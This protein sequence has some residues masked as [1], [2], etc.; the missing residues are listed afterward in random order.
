ML[1]LGL[2]PALSLAQACHPLNSQIRDVHVCYQAKNQSL[3]IRINASNWQLPLD[4]YS[5]SPMQI[6]P[7]WPNSEGF[8]LSYVD[9]AGFSA[10]GSVKVLWWRSGVLTPI[11]GDKLF[12]NLLYAF[13]IDGKVY[14]VLMQHYTEDFYYAS[15]IIEIGQDG[16]SETSDKLP[17]SKV[18]ADYKKKLNQSSDGYAKS[19][20]FAFIASAYIRMNDD[21][22]AQKYIALSKSEHAGVVPFLNSLPAISKLSQKPLQSGRWCNAIPSTHS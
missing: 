8:V 17:W 19:T 1:L 21:E 3:A 14:L 13:S 5:A 10:G 20:Y 12:A 15:S 9:L 4:G 7:L 6:S 18:V 16:W 11:C 2:M 22:M